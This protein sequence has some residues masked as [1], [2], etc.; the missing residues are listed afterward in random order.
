VSPSYPAAQTQPLCRGTSQGKSHRFL[1]LES[2]AV[3]ARYPKT[4]WSRQPTWPSTSLY[5][6]SGTMSSGS[7][8]HYGRPTRRSCLG[9][10]CN[11]STGV[12][13]RWETRASAEI[14]D[15]VQWAL[16]R[17]VH[18]IIHRHWS[19]SGRFRQTYGYRHLSFA[20]CTTDA[21]MARW[22]GKDSVAGANQCGKTLMNDMR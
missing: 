12:S 22:L 21:S 16:R 19:R 1:A 18:H 11:G 6:C 3:H 13:L 5:R 7:G 10:V 2:K 20:I 4:S 8:D 15:D 14:S 17:M 9:S